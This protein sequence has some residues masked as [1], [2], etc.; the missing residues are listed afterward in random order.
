RHGRSSLPAVARGRRQLGPPFGAATS[1]RWGAS[2][3]PEERGGTAGCPPDRARFLRKLERDLPELRLS[4]TGIGP[5]GEQMISSKT[6]KVVNNLTV[7]P[8][9]NEDLNNSTDLLHFLVKLHLMSFKI[10]NHRATTK[11]RFGRLGQ[12]GRVNPPQSAERIRQGG[13]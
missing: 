8:R 6:I 9:R 1:F 3:F 4:R 11:L 12:H 13:H 10:L 2:Q 5:C 7:N